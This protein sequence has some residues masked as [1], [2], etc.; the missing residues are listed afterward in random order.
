MRTKTIIRRKAK[1]GFVVYLAENRRYLCF[2]FA[3]RALGLHH[4]KLPGRLQVELSS[5]ERPGFK[6]L[7]VEGL[8]N[9]EGDNRAFQWVWWNHK[10]F[11][12][13]RVYCAMG[14]DLTRLF[15][16]GGEHC[17]FFRITDVKTLVDKPRP[18]R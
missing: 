14:E 5:K 2:D 9:Y 10:L 18:V 6:K 12:A 13:Q 16:D 7:F 3:E 17:L 1:R 15:P 8:F 11:G 4:S